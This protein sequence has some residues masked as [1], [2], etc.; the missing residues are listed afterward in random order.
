MLLSTLK[1]SIIF[2]LAFW[3]V[4]SARMSSAETVIDLYQSDFVYGTY[5]IDEPGIYRLAEDISFN[6]NSTALL[7]TDAYHAGFPMPN[8]FA[9]SGPY[10]PRAFG[11]GFFAAIAITAP[12]V[13]LDLAGHT[14]EQSKEHALL[15]RFFAVIELADQPFIPQQGPADFGADIKSAT[16]VFIMNGT[17]GRS[18][19]HGIHGNGNRFVTIWNVHFKDF[20][21]AAVALNGV[22]GLWIQNSTATNRK[23]VP[24]T[25]I[26]SS[27]QFI[28]AY[29]EFL[30]QTNSSTVLHVGGATLS[31]TD[32]RGAIRD[33]INNV[34]EDLII[35]G[36]PSIDEVTHPDEYALFHNPF[37]IIDGNSYGYLV[38]G[39]GVAVNGFPRRPDYIE[40][41]PS[42]N[43]WLRNV[44]VIDQRAFINEVIAINQSGLAVTDPV[45][46]VFQIRNLHPDTELPITISSLDDSQ[47][48]Y[49]GNAVAN[50]Q[51]FVAK[52]YLNG[53]F[54]GSFL[55]LSRLN[56]TQEVLDFVEAAPG[57]EKL[58]SL[59]PSR[60]DYFC[61]GDSMFHV[62]KGVIGFKMDAAENVM[63]NRT[64]AQVIENIGNAGSDVCGPYDKSHPKATLIG[65]GGATA[66][67][68]SFAGSSQVR[69][70]NSKV[71][72]LR[73]KSG[74]ATAFDIL[75]DSKDVQISNCSAQEVEAGWGF[76]PNPDSPTGIPQTTA[77]HVGPDARMVS[78]RNV[79][80]Y[81]LYA[82]DTTAVVNDES[83]LSM[84][85]NLCGESW[86][87]PRGIWGRFFEIN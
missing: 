62:N 65:Y 44:H 57:K 51:A 8:Q 34:H 14:I 10:N 53:D 84:L 42:R 46:A 20:E 48:E 9:P 28:K 50:A 27:A 24:V 85:W 6:P 5:I 64:S 25:G 79:C 54:D 41:F 26:Y 61:N 59:V 2:S 77:F 81:G 7:G 3:F 18:A 66:R 40:T 4:V 60:E 47:A 56:I 35:L 12:N 29:I 86:K 58:L 83:E 15:Q 67:G 75:T 76:V 16:N 32:I 30:V 17:I 11:I 55:D 71:K 22:E 21:V 36:K 70:S 37:G 23:D 87:R 45:G 19:H 49:V 52:A 72:D 39:L 82:Y 43:I 73:A 78:L 38:N 68:Y 31:A 33:A 63:L 1:R 80:G 74:S 13:V 69:V